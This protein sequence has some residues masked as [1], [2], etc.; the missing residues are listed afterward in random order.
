M[1]TTVSGE[2]LLY[3]SQHIDAVHS[4]HLHIA[5]DQ[6]E[7]L[8]LNGLEGIDS[9]LRGNNVVPFFFQHDRQEIAHALF[10]IDDQYLVH[11][12]TSP[13]S[14]S[15]SAIRPFM[16][17]ACPIPRS[18]GCGHRTGYRCPSRLST[19][20]GPSVVL[21]DTVHDGESQPGASDLGREERIED[22]R[23]VRLRDPRYR[24]PSPDL[25]PDRIVLDMRKGNCAD[26]QVRRHSG[27][28]WH[29]LI[30]RFQ[31]T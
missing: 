7:D 17:A 31:N 24:C 6:I 11:G 12:I 25:T 16:I 14:A 22:L 27:I 15:V 20:I 8:G 19:V 9:R 10:V 28:A 4:G 30:S 2:H 5:D 26:R 18:W 3:R 21:D 1:M 13:P 23:E 29:A